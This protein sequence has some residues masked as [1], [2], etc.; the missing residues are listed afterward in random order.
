MQN[1]IKQFNP[2]LKAEKGIT[3][4]LAVITLSAA[5]AT[6]LF[7]AKSLTKEYTISTELANSLKAV[8][9]ADSAIEYTLYQVRNA[10]YD[11]ILKSVDINLPNGIHTLSCSGFGGACANSLTTLQTLFTNTDVP[12]LTPLTSSS[13][14]VK[15]QLIA[16]GTTIGC[17][18][19]TTAPNC[20]YLQTNGSY[21]GTNRAMEIIY[22][23]K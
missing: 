22:E 15:G 7:V 9:V 19:S 17:P 8:Y 3:L 4:Y 14:S 2:P 1:K 20:M 10:T 11:P 13:Y 21:G 16:P 12:G 6:A 23:N 18:V 5:L